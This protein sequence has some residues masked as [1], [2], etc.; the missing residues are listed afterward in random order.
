MDRANHAQI[1]RSGIL[2]DRQQFR[3][4]YRRLTGCENT[5]SRTPTIKDL[6]GDL[7]NRKNGFYIPLTFLY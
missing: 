7:V 6:A 2:Q 3:G 5:L 4:I 1:E